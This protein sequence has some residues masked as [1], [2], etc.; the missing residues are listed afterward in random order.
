MTSEGVFQEV[1]K[2]SIARRESNQ[3]ERGLAQHIRVL[4]PQTTAAPHLAQGAALGMGM[5][6]RTRQLAG[7]IP[8]GTESKGRLGSSPLWL[9]ANQPN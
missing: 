4:I 2:C 8:Q 5:C 6:T 1:P 3:R 7:F 9:S